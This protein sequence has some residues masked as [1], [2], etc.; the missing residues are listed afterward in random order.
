MYYFRL[1]IMASNTSSNIYTTPV[2]Q[3]A[4]SEAAA[5]ATSDSTTPSGPSLSRGR[6][7]QKATVAKTWTAH[8]LHLITW[9]R[10]DLDKLP[11]VPD[12]NDPHAKEDP[13]RTF[14]NLVIQAFEEKKGGITGLLPNQTLVEQWACCMEPHQSTDAESDPKP[15]KAPQ[16]STDAESDTDAPVTTH[17]NLHHFDMVIKTRKQVR[18]KDVWKKF[19]DTYKISLNFSDKHQFQKYWS[20]YTYITKKDEHFI[21][22]ESHACLPGFKKPLEPFSRSASPMSSVASSEDGDHPVMIWMTR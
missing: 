18:V 22:D 17:K 11:T 20:A 15:Q 8:K 9:S 5:M 16:Q 7:K 21:R 10:A 6:G 1:L 12:Q 19:R 4:N 2:R 14:A 13:R 3:S